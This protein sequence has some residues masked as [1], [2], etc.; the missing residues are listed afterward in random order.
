MVPLSS[1]YEGVPLHELDSISLEVNAAGETRA[2]YA[3]KRADV[4]SGSLA[5]RCLHYA[6]EW[7]RP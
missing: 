6:K 7:V 2:M 4:M 3:T 1:E 5:C